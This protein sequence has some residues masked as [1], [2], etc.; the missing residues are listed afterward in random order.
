MST[1]TKKP[2]KKAAKKTSK[3]TSKKTQSALAKATVGTTPA[4]LAAMPAGSVVFFEND[5]LTYVTLIM[6][7]TSGTAKTCERIIEQTAPM[8][9]ALRKQLA[10]NKRAQARR[11]KELAMLVEAM[12]TAKKPKKARKA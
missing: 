9:Q 3:K 2:A 6:I 11:D 8:M 4:R 10:D 12:P 7:D 1:P 5:D